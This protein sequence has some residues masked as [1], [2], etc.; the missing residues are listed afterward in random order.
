MSIETKLEE[1]NI[2]LESLPAREMLNP[3]TQTGNLI[4]TSGQVCAKQGELVSLG[5]IG[6]EVTVEEGKKGAEQSIINCL[7]GLKEYLGDLD[8]ISKIVKVQ[9]F[10]QSADDFTNQRLVMDAASNLLHLI[11]GEKGKHSRTGVGVN[12]LPTNASVEIEMIVEIK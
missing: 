11:F 8:K 10:I 4:F 2:N 1:L 3:V 6:R 5:K 7:S 9:G 12:V